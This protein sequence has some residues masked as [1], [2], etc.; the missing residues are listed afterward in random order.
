MLSTTDNQLERLS[1]IPLTK[2]WS[3]SNLTIKNT[4]YITHGIYTYP[5]KFIPQLSSKLIA[6]YSNK[7]DIIIDTFMG[8]GTTIIEAI[9]NNRIAIGNDINEIA[10]LLSKVKSTPIDNNLLYDAY[11]KLLSNLDYKLNIGFQEE[12]KVAEKYIQLH[13]RID[14][15]FKPHIKNQLTIILYNILQFDNNDIKDFFLI[16]FCQILKSCSIWMQ[17]SVKPTRDLQ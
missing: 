11:T 7:E 4:S 1:K 17:K 16:V 12:L 9:I 2:Q 10:L 8:S 13:K 15:W 3:F 14:Y 6:E 5:A